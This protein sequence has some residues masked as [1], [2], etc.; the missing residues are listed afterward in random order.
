MEENGGYWIRSCRVKETYSPKFSNFEGPNMKR[1]IVATKNDAQVTYCLFT[2]FVSM[3][4]K[5]DE[6]A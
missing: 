1:E 5:G 2:T 6:I 3:P 4:M